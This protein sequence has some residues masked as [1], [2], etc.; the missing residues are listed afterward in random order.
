MLA[1]LLRR[2]EAADINSLVHDAS[3]IRSCFEGIRRQLPGE[4][5]RILQ[6]VAFMEHRCY[7]FE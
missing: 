5:I 3:G 4:L 1:D 7:D 6:P 2:L